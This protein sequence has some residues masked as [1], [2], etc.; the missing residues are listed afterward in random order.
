MVQSVTAMLLDDIISILSDN[1]G[2]LT[3]ALLKTKILLRQ[4]GHK[5]LVSWVN[6]ELTGYAKEDEVP[7]YRQVHTTPHASVI[8]NGWQYKDTLL[9][10][11]TLSDG[12]RK[13]VTELNINSSIS[14]IEEQV[15]KYHQ[16]KLGLVRPLSPDYMPL[17]TKGLVKGAGI[18]SAWCEINMA[19]VEAILIQVRSRLLDFCLELKEALGNASEQEVPEKSAKIDTSGMFQT[20][21]YGGT[22]VI[23]GANVHVN[24]KEGDIVGLLDEVGKLGYD[25]EELEELRKAVEADT[26]PNVTDGETSKWYLNALKKA[27]KGAIKVGTDVVSN[28]I[29]KAMERYVGS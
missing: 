18:L 8:L 22:V 1:R 2:S 11:S 10:L 28:V 14:T 16:D 13:N 21:V 19:E 6:S 12:L 3:D 27:G 29:I 25:K 17:L 4:L 9:P 23:G 26:K 15:E 5:E 24:N 7:D 20:I